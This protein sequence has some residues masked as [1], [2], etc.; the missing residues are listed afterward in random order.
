MEEEKANLF[1]GE[2][3][4]QVREGEN[5]PTLGEEGARDTPDGQFPW[6]LLAWSVSG[7][8]HRWQ[9]LSPGIIFFAWLRRQHSLLVSLLP[10]QLFPLHLLCWPVLIALTSGS[11]LGP[12]LSCS[13]I[14]SWWSHPLTWFHILSLH[15]Q[16][17]IYNSRP[18][19]ST[20]PQSH[21]TMSLSTSPHMLWDISNM[22]KVKL[23][24][25]SH[26]CH[27][28]LHSFPHPNKWRLHLLVDQPKKL[29]VI[30]DFFF[31]SHPTSNL[32]VD[33][34]CSTFKS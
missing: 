5:S 26:S 16:L 23:Q 24:I 2:K 14:F 12:P 27:A 22:P 1:D 28:H 13:H 34:A 4:E 8:W 33:L 9:F 10:H 31:L 21:I 19:I 18:S 11:V 7:I 3:W 6:S 17:H 32:I 29:S 20:E 30:L 25:L 15:W